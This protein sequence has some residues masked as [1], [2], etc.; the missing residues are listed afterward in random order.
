MG[1]SVDSLKCSYDQILDRLEKVEY[2]TEQV[3]HGCDFQSPS[4]ADDRVFGP[5]TG[6]LTDEH[7]HKKTHQGTAEALPDLQADFNALK[8]ALQKIKFPSEYLLND[9]KAGI[10]KDDLYRNFECSVKISKL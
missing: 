7:Y 4:G 9:S 3:A 1:S 2:K 8:D 10:R 5:A 6:K